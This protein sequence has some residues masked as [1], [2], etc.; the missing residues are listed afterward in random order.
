[1]FLRGFL[2]SASSSET[3]ENTLLSRLVKPN[4][5]KVFDRI[6]TG[7]FGEVFKARWL[8][9]QV[10]AVKVLRISPK[11]KLEKTQQLAQFQR[12]IQLLSTLQHPNIV[13]FLGA[14]D[15]DIYPPYFLCEFLNCGTLTKWLRHSKPQLTEDLSFARDAAAALAFLHAQTPPIIHR[16]VKS[17]NYLVDE[18]DGRRSLK[19]SDFGLSR[20]M[21]SLGEKMTPCGTVAYSAPEVIRCEAYSEKADVYGFGIVFW[22]IMTHNMDPYPGCSPLQVQMKVSLQRVRPRVPSDF[23]DLRIPRLMHLCWRER[24][25][26]RPSMA[27]VL[28]LLNQLHREKCGQF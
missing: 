12:E 9:A 3:K 28:Q 14:S 7:S 8:G 17:D 22:Q 4:E 2:T 6:G 23:T 25:E 19:L 1:M 11:S 18:R 10:V 15:H 27:A 13:R 16:D 26:Q 24:P 21:A 5:L 20:V